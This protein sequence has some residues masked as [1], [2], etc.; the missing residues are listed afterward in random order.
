MSWLTSVST[1]CSLAESPLARRREVSYWHS[2]D[3]PRWRADGR[4]RAESRTERQ[5]EPAAV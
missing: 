4:F 2:R 3:L 5:Q 1:I